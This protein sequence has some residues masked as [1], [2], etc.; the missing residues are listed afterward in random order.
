MAYQVI[1]KRSAEKELDAL[2]ANIRDR[3][4]KRLLT[5]EENPRP[6]GIK[7]LQ[8]QESYRLR[9]GDYRVLYDIDDKAKQIFIL[10]VGHRRE[11]Y[12]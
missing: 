10:G 5:L 2:Q 1:L 9:V 8:G 4:L 11:V 12:R 3:I 6:S 7:K